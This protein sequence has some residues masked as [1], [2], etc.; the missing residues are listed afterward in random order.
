TDIAEVQP[1]QLGLT[2]LHFDTQARAIFDRTR[3]EAVWVGDAKGRLRIVET[4]QGRELAA[5]SA[6]E[7]PITGLTWAGAKGPMVTV[8]LD[9]ATKYWNWTEEKIVSARP[10]VCCCKRPLVGV[11]ATADGCSVACV[12][13]TGEVAVMDSTTGKRL[14]QGSIG[15]VGCAESRSIPLAF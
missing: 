15:P 14:S 10:P 4:K 7:G 13:C 12:D 11:A 6:H 5:I 2:Q 9:G 8:S 3:S 1:R